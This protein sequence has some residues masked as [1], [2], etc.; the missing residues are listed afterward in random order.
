MKLVAGIV[1]EVAD[2]A[3]VGKIGVAA[4]LVDSVVGE[5]VAAGVVGFELAELKGFQMGEHSIH[6]VGSASSQNNITAAKS[7]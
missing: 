7:N 2:V 3:A 4:D 6:E 5:V 1:V